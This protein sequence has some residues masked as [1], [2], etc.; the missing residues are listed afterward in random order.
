MLAIRKLTFSDTSI[1]RF[2][3]KKIPEELNFTFIFCRTKGHSV[4]KGGNKDVFNF[5]PTKQVQAHSSHSDKMGNS[6]VEHLSFLLDWRQ[7]IDQ[8]FRFCLVTQYANYRGKGW[9]REGA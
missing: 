5:L 6:L 8:L 3:P 2:W 4:N 1:R 7:H 9:M